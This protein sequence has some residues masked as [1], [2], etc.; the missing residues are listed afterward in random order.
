M[1]RFA[2]IAALLCGTA[3]D[4]QAQ[5]FR[6]ANDGDVNSM[7]PYTRQET[8]LLAFG[9]NSTSRWCGG[10]AR[11]GRSRRWPSAGNSPPRPSGA[12]ICA[13]A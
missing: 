10:T 8:F 4:A 12:S 5:V 7:D 13:G 11:C 1:R 6:W 2:L 3:L 9:S